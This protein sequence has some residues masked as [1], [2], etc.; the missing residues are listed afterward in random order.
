MTNREWLSKM[1][2]VDMLSLLNKAD[3]P[4]IFERLG[5]ENVSDRCKKFNDENLPVETCCYNCLCAW[6]N[7]ICEK[8]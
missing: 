7:E 8:P 2:L 5:D 3:M 6:L 1:S 4:C